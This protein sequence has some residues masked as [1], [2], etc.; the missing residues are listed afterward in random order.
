MDNLLC[1]TNRKYIYKSIQVIIS[2]SAAI[3][4]IELMRISGWSIGISFSYLPRLA[5]ILKKCDVIFKT[6]DYYWNILI[7]IIRVYSG[8]AIA[9]LIA[10]PMAVLITECRWFNYIFFPLVEIVRPIPNA[11][12]VP[13]SILLFKSI[14]GSVLFITFVGAFFP[15]LINSIEGL[16]NVNPNYIKIAKSFKLKPIS[17]ICEVKIPAAGPNIYTGVLLGMSGSWLG[18]V[19]A[20]MMNGESGIGYM[21]WVNYT[22]VDISGVI[23]CMFTIG[24]LGALSGVFLRTVNNYIH[25]SGYENNEEMY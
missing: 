19:V 12:W 1:A 11:A 2:L 8:F 6:Q 14:D 23:I 13:L 21:T 16:S 10:L 17:Y 24:L 3:I 20:E 4:I 22:L 5:D 25:W 15:I 7:S 9:F 18:V